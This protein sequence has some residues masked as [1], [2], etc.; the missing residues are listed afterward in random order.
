MRELPPQVEANIVVVTGFESTRIGDRLAKLIESE[1]GIKIGCG[2]CRSSLYRLNAMTSA[3]VIGSSEEIAESIRLR[4]ISI[5]PKWW[6]R[7]GATLLPSVANSKL[8][9]LIIKAANHSLKK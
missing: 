4:A 5:A 7:F 9:S 8:Q 1:I 6:Q 2:E 3:E